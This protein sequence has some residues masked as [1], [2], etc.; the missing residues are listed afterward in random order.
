MMVDSYFWSV[1]KTC[2]PCR[3]LLL[4]VISKNVRQ[5]TSKELKDSTVRGIGECRSNS[6]QWRNW[7]RG[8]PP[9]LRFTWQ[10]P[11]WELPL[12]AGFLRSVPVSDQIL[13]ILLRRQL[14]WKLRLKPKS[15][16][17]V[18]NQLGRARGFR[19]GASTDQSQ[20]KP[21]QIRPNQ[22]HAGSGENKRR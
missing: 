6:I 20:T 4:A 10:S 21:E 15:V 1:G 18:Y 3:H 9:Y 7:S 5:L 17:I 2:D 14:H 16:I 13:G 22:R 19:V 11:V 12:S 8:Y